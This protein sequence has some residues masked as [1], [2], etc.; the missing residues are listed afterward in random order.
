[1]DR[2]ADLPS[3]AAHRTTVT[4]RLDRTNQYAVAP[5][6][7]HERCGMLDHPLSRMMTTECTAGVLLQR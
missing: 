7:K 1:M 2:F 3:R 5:A 4:A 6:I